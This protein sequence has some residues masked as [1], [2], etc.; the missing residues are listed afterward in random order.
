MWSERSRHG[1]LGTGPGSLGMDAGL[2]MPAAVPPVSLIPRAKIH[3]VASPN[4][5]S[6]LGRHRVPAA[7]R[8]AAFEDRCST[9]PSVA[10]VRN[11]DHPA[12]LQASLHGIVTTLKRWG[13]AGGNS[14]E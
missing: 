14:I 7:D 5:S 3:A 13:H 1:R 10:H 4:R 9:G 11:D 6:T 8:P 2:A 12:Q